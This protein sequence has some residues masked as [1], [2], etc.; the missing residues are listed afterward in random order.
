MRRKYKRKHLRQIREDA[1]L[2]F[3]ADNLKLVCCK[4]KLKD[5]MGRDNF[6]GIC[7]A[8]EAVLPAQSTCMISLGL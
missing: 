1:N 2:P 6:S 5:A 7:T 3:D 8:T 4:F